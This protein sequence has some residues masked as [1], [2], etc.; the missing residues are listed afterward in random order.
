[1]DLNRKHWKRKHGEIRCIPLDEWDSVAQGFAAD[2]SYR[3]KLRH[4]YID[5]AVR[6]YANVAEPELR[7]PK[8]PM[9]LEHTGEETE[10]TFRPADFRPGRLLAKSVRTASS[11]MVSGTQLTRFYETSAFTLLM[12]DEHD[13]FSACALLTVAKESV[14]ASVCGWPASLQIL[15]AASGRM[16]SYIN[17]WTSKMMYAL[18]GWSTGVGADYASRTMREYA[19]GIGEQFLHGPG[20]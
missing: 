14:N 17:W 4:Q 10:L 19:V 16:R 20:E 12:F 11:G 7:F 3:D 13:Y 8:T 1:M 5:M 9:S 18:Q 2:V 15:R 6:G